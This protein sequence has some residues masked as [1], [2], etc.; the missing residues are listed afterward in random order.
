MEDVGLEIE[1]SSEVYTCVESKGFGSMTIWIL[2]SDQC[3]A[4]KDHVEIF[5]WALFKING[6]SEDVVDLTNDTVMAKF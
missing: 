6:D 1:C 5:N 2:A 3:G 4:F